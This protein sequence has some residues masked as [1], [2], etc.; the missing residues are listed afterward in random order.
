MAWGNAATEEAGNEHIGLKL[1]NRSLVSFC[2][3]DV[4]GFLRNV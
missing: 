2:V 4:Q 1:V 3:F